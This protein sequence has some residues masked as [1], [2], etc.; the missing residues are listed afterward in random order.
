VGYLARYNATTNQVMISNSSVITGELISHELFHGYQDS[1]YPGMGN[2]T[3]P[4]LTNIEFE[5]YVFQSIAFSMDNYSSNIGNQ[6]SNVTKAQEFRQ[7]IQGLTNSGVTFPNLSNIADFNSQYNYFLDAFNTYGPND[8][9]GKKTS[10]D[11]TALKDFF[12]GEGC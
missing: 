7:W 11:P 3:G 6:I 8:Y 4:G 9:R 10:S 1:K 5:Q 2:G 12:N